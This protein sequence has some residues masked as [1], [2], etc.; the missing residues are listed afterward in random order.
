M[1]GLAIPIG[2]IHIFVTF[3]RGSEFIRSWVKSDGSWVY[4]KLFAETMQG[5]SLPGTQSHLN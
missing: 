3:G 1:D 4:V 2:E 5:V